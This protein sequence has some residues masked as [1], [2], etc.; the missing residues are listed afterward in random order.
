MNRREFLGV[1]AALPFMGMLPEQALAA[2][3]QRVLVLVK[4]A[5]GNDGL[6]TLV[7]YTDPLYY[8]YRPRV[9]VPKH[10]VLDIGQNM[11]LNPYMK[12]LKPAWD[13]GELAFVQ[14][15]GYPGSD[16]SHFR[17]SDIWEAGCGANEYASEGWLAQVMPG[18]KS[19]LHGIILGES[20]GPLAGK[21]CHTVAM[22]SPQVFLSQIDLVDNIIPNRQTP[23]LAHLTNI[24][25]QLYDAGQQLRSKLA[26]PVAL[27]VNFSTS[28]LGRD[29]ESVAKM[30]LSG[31]DAAV[32]M[33]TLD[34]FDTHASQVNTQGNLL[35]R[36]GVALDSFAQAMK[37]GGRWNDVLV[38]TYSEFGRRV[39]ENHAGGT[40][41]GTASVQMVMG[42]KVRGGLYGEAPRL[43]ELDADGNLHHTLDY[44]AVYGTLTQNWLRQRN[45]WSSFG[46]VP[47]V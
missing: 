26:R 25:Q 9:A 7:P 6:N 28:D 19:G 35:N 22:Q 12:A 8:Q 21:D 3:G 24:Q 31:V 29:L 41:H 43:R 46:T 15:V 20:M 36:L 5:G 1:A 4:L 34:G 39:Q 11:G 33:V 40:D 17:S 27:G 30:I 47:F 44:R 38:V 23:A 42:G 45:P 14:G 37:R 16:L 32:Y 2:A 13:A 18:Y 10:Q